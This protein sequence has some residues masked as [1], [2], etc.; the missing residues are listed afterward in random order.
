HEE[1][2]RRGDHLAVAALAGREVAQRQV[3]GAAV[4]HVEPDLVGHDPGSGG[5]PTSVRTTWTVVEGIRNSERMSSPPQARLPDASGVATV[6]RWTPSGVSTHTPPGPVTQ[7]L[8]CSSH[9]IPSTLPSRGIPLPMFS[10][11]RRPLLSEPS[12]ATSKTLT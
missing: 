1:R 10:A 6:P 12:G 5:G 7:T 8:P 4:E 11:N 3:R 9:S 2:R